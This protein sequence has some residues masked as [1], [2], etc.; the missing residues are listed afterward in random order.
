[1]KKNNELQKFYR[2]VYSKGETKHFTSFL[3]TGKPTTE[4]DYVFKESQWKGKKVLDV[5]CGTGYFAHKIAKKGAI[6]LGI[7]YADEAIL[8]AK[9][10]YQHKNL[11]FK[12]LDVKD[13][14]EKY[15]IITSLGTFEHLDSPFKILKKM[16][17][18]LKN[19]GKIILTNPNWLNPRGYV[20]MTLYFLFNAPITLADIHYLT[21]ND[22]KEWAKKINM[23]LKWKTFD[24]S[25][26]HGEI[27]LQDFKRRLPNVLKDT[28][29]PNDKKQIKKFISWLEK[30][31][32]DMN[33]TLPHSGAI[34]IYIYS[35][36]NKIKN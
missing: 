12:K 28:K 9:K 27:L 33:N 8:I 24:F 17:D 11:E 2:K 34:G 15:D 13:I 31:V 4:A 30:N 26:A 18:H 25:W 23:N 5:G 1:M 7:D 3:T 21:P 29:L 6:V 14:A 36:K 20:L 19:N 16:R 22:H 10:K 32:V 35:K